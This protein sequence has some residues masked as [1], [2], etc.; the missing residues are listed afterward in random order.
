[1]EQFSQ[2]RTRSLFGTK[3]MRKRLMSLFAAAVMVFC[4]V[5]PESLAAHASDMI[6]RIVVSGITDPVL[7][8]KPVNDPAAYTLDI[9]AKAEIVW[10]KWVKLNPSDLASKKVSSLDAIMYQ[11]T[12]YTDSASVP[13]LLIG[14]NRKQGYFISDTVAVFKDSADSMKNMLKSNYT[15]FLTECGVD[16]PACD[17][18]FGYEHYVINP[19]I[20]SVKISGLT[21]PMLG[22]QPAL[23]PS[24]YSTTADADITGVTWYDYEGKEMTAESYFGASYSYA[25]FKLTAHEGYYF[26]Q[27]ESGL[28]VTLDGTF[29]TEPKVQSLSVSSD[30][31][32]MR[33][34]YLFTNRITEPLEEIQFT[35][36]PA[37]VVGAYP[38]TQTVAFRTKESG[39]YSVHNVFWF[40][41]KT[42]KQV[43]GKF[44]SGEKYHAVFTVKPYVGYSFLFHATEKTPTT[45]VEVTAA[46][47]VSV[48]NKDDTA[49]QWG[50]EIADLMR[51]GD[52]CVDAVLD[53]KTATTIDR[54]F[55][56]DD[57]RQPVAEE[58]PV[59]YLPD[60]P[61]GTIEKISWVDESDGHV[62]GADELFKSSRK[63]TVRITV[64]P[65]YGYVFD[66]KTQT[67]T[68]NGEK[69]RVE[70][71]QFKREDGTTVSCAA[72]CRT[73]TADSFGGT[74]VY[75][76]VGKSLTLT[77]TKIKNKTSV[78]YTWTG[79][80]YHRGDWRTGYTIA[81]YTDE[82]KFYNGSINHHARSMI[83]TSPD[84]SGLTNAYDGA[85]VE[86]RAWT[87]KEGT[88][89]IQRFH[90]HLCG[91]TVSHQIIMRRPK[92]DDKYEDILNSIDT[93][94]FV[95][96]GTTDNYIKITERD[97][98][99]I[100]TR[101]MQKGDVFRAGCEY[102]FGFRLTLSDAV[103]Q[104]ALLGFYDH[105]FDFCEESITSSADGVE[106]RTLDTFAQ[107]E[108]AYRID[109]EKRTVTD[110]WISPVIYPDDPQKCGDKLT[111][112]YRPS[113]EIDGI[114]TGR[115]LMIRGSG[116]M[117]DYT[118]TQ[119]SPWATDTYEV[120]KYAVSI[121]FPDALTH[122]GD[123]AFYQTR[124]LESVQ[125]PRSLKSIGDSAFADAA[126]LKSVEIPYSV[127]KIGKNAFADCRALTKITF[128]NPDTKIADD[129]ST[130]SNNG[131]LF[132][133]VIVGWEG[134]TAQAYAEA[135]NRAFRSLGKKPDGMCGDHLWWYYDKSTKTL[136]IKGEGDMYDSYQFIENRAE[137]KK[138]ELP[139]GLTGIGIAAFCQ[140]GISEIQIPETVRRIGADAFSFADGLISV[141]I[142]AGVLSVGDQAF[143]GTT[144][145]DII[146]MGRETVLPDNDRTFSGP[147]DPKSP[148][149]KEM[150][151][152]GIVHGYKN[153]TAHEYAQTYGY[154]FEAFAPEKY[155]VSFDAG[156]GSGTMQ[157]VEVD[158]DTEFVVP[159]CT[160]MPPNGKVFKGWAVQEMDNDMKYMPGAVITVKQNMTLTAIWGPPTRMRGDVSGN[161]G[162]IDTADAMLLTRYVNGWEGVVI[163]LTLADLDQDGEVGVRDA[164]IITRYVNGWEGYDEYFTDD[165]PA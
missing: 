20:R 58:H 140:T 156:F 112:G 122:I 44:V 115:E 143:F 68:I 151:F 12:F 135:N 142:P 125:L 114:E 65:S 121:S 155:T 25:E 9:P 41:D 110:S 31:K 97:T 1:M 149:S 137:I 129:A 163:D 113:M 127:T 32:T 144:L 120:N 49:K 117:Y 62:L 3:H 83:A 118:K 87:E 39:K 148:N 14:V 51:S 134:S 157:P 162:I 50:Q 22:G 23:E 5:M 71:E 88:L 109:L 24:A 136:T 17:M 164:M 128:W 90:L 86:C 153:S 70:S 111:W 74:D 34:L 53:T 108:G 43:T 27:K 37:P 28:T 56:F 29:E 132:S 99:H 141:K 80:L 146:F 106:T 26:K 154:R 147:K 79:N 45:K 46:N 93:G 11:D 98:K 100:V 161:D 35:S 21:E 59:T 131:V 66:L 138:I 150:I 57:L 105:G 7:G 78:I 73:F 47:S 85:W 158:E 52:I 123:Y 89:R 76:E 116:D 124:S 103:A 63:Y 107:S 55:A 18:I 152:D 64:S 2:H 159:E 104:E 96:N 75:F 16:Y 10:A 19:A 48:Y 30:G 15:E 33:V 126:L 133:G 130:I 72:F 145:S 94:D 38:N 139:E 6:T 13:A 84:P 42:K 77:S 40:S 4:S 81:E 8:E 61:F 82:D 36:I 60:E 91:D 101:E 54:A 69:C 160:F 95:L 119:L 92:A 67:G 165:T 102:Y